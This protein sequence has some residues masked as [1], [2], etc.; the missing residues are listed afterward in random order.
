VEKTGT[1]KAEKIPW[2]YEIQLLVGLIDMKSIGQEK[3]NLIHGTY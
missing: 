2:I 3:M 1:W